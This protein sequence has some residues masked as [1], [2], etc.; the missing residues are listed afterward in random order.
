MGRPKLSDWQDGNTKPTEVGVY[1][2]KDQWGTVHWSYWHGEFWNTTRF[3]KYD[4]LRDSNRPFHSVAQ[5]LKW[6]GKL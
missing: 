6:R 4:A 2:R 5:S 3:F 1:Q